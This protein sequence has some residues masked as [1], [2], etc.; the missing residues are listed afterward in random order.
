ML[1]N[2]HVCPLT[3]MVLES[4]DSCLSIVFLGCRYPVAHVFGLLRSMYD[5]LSKAILSFFSSP[6][7]SETVGQ[8]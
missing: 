8:T 6:S 5:Q 1:S 3:E 7:V 4:F 2:A